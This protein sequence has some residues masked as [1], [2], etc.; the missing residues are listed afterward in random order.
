MKSVLIMRLTAMGD[1]AM[2]AP[3]VA[4]V[5][6]ANPDVHFT[7]LST[8]LFEPFFEALPNFTFIGTAIRKENSGLP[9][10]WRLFSE[11]RQRGGEGDVIPAKFDT[12]IDLHDVLRTKVLRSLFRLSGVRVFSIDK[13]RSAKKRLVEGTLRR[14]LKPM[15]ER[16]ADTFRAAGLTV[17]AERHVR[18]K[19]QIP[20]MLLPLA[21]HRAG[22][23]WVGISPFA[24]HRGKMY[25]SDNMI[26]VIEGL[27]QTPDVR[28]FLFGGGSVEAEAVRLMIEAATPSNFDLRERCFNAINVMTLRDE[29]SLMAHLDCMVSMDSSNMHICSLFGVRVVSLWGGT[30][31]FAGFLG[32]GQDPADVIQRN[33]LDCRPCSV[34]GNIPCRSGDYKCLDID[35][36]IV[37]D[38]VF[39]KIPKP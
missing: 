36:Q 24:Q 16:Y 34:F 2:T 8:P 5:C 37:I 23:T 25:P 26:K 27:L 19:P 15:T 33:D 3:I 14:Q 22:E 10:L 35:P 28:I 39:A 38:R 11:L 6:G 20:Q 32:Y 9:G 29:M 13:G 21:A 7:V 1:V 31:P 30:H 4:S 18:P 12:V 17:P